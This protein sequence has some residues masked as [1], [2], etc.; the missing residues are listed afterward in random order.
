MKINSDCVRAPFCVRQMVRDLKKVAREKAVLEKSSKKDIEDF[1]VVKEEY[2]K[3]EKIHSNLEAKIST[4]SSGKEALEDRFKVLYDEHEVMKSSESL[5]RSASAGMKIANKALETKTKEMS[6]KNKELQR[7][8]E[9]L[10]GGRTKAVDKVIKQKAA[11]KSA[12]DVATNKLKIQENKNNEIVK[13]LEVIENQNAVNTQNLSKMME[14]NLE[15]KSAMEVLKTQKAHLKEE[16]GKKSGQETEMKKVHDKIRSNMSQCKTDLSNLESVNSNCKAKIGEL[17]ICK[18]EISKLAKIVED[19]LSQVKTKNDDIVTFREKNDI[20]EQNLKE[21]KEELELF[22]SSLEKKARVLSELETRLEQCEAAQEERTNRKNNEDEDITI[23]K[24]DSPCTISK[25]A[26]NDLIS[27]D[28]KTE[29]N[30]EALKVENKILSKKLEN[31]GESL[32][33]C[34][35]KVVPDISQAASDSILRELLS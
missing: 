23:L 22:N 26:S 15:L 29:E 24:C 12:L 13:S 9:Q 16:V 1:N 14:E 4:L 35:Q 18:S 34:Q 5:L 28:T 3:L 19:R 11:L 32:T 33:L 6:T 25:L 27:I 7:K 31:I 10:E 20:L 30:M 8:V 21:A 2:G 17:N